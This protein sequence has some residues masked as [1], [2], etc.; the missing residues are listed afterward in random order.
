MTKTLYLMRHGETLFNVLGRIQGWC[1]SPLTPRGIAQAK[2]AQAWFAAQGVAF[3]AAYCS[4]AE[5]AADTLELVTTRPYTRHKGLRECGFGRFEGQAEYLNP[6]PPYGD[7]F[8]PYG[9]ES[10]ATID[11]RIG[12]TVADLMAQAT[13]E[14]V[15]MVS[16]AGAIHHFIAQWT[17]PTTALP[18][19]RLPNCAIVQF[20]YGA[21]QFRFVRVVA[22]ADVD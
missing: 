14:T 20:D 15:L 21:G 22:P 1:D 16:H 2:Q 11:A 18:D 17:D 4:T 19:H 9:G 13:G 7:F 5:R 3:D 6:Q 10:Q 8:V 12:G